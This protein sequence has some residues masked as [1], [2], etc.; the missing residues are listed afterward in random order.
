MKEF[1]YSERAACK[2]LGMDR[3]SYLYEPKPDRNEMLRQDLNEL[4]RQKPRYGYR[5]LH[6]LLVF[7]LRLLLLVS[8]EEGNDLWQLASTSTACRIVLKSSQLTEH[9]VGQDVARKTSDRS[10]RCPLPGQCARASPNPTT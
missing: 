4:A 9:W 6:V 8:R 7:V 1:S 5:R 10:C 2:L 3:T